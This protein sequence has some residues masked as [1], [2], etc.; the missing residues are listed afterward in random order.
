[1]LLDHKSPVSWSPEGLLAGGSVAEAPWKQWYTSQGRHLESD[2]IVSTS[3]YGS[4]RRP[5]RSKF[6]LASEASLKGEVIVGKDILQEYGEAVFLKIKPLAS[7][8][9]PTASKPNPLQSKSHDF[10][11]IW[12]PANSFTTI[13]TSRMLPG[14]RTV[15]TLSSQHRT[16]G[17]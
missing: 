11:E 3:W 12:G 7:R 8:K 1:M 16:R 5:I 17:R 10:L 9:I 2:R 4:L 6:H 14:E 15:P 13:E